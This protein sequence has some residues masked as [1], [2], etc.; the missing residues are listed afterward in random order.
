ME[1]CHANTPLSV[2]MVHNLRDFGAKF[3]QLTGYSGQN[4]AWA[5]IQ[6]AP[7]LFQS[8]NI[9]MSNVCGTWDG[10]STCHSYSMTL[11]SVQRTPKFGI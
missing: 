8:L 11:V 7:K 3:E 1:L 9:L 10:N 6:F 2:K 4:T 5:W